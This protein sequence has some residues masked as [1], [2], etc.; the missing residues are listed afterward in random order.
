MDYNSRQ[1]R[2]IY[3]QTE[4]YEPLHTCTLPSMHTKPFKGPL[5]Y[6]DALCN[7]IH[8]C[9]HRH[10]HTHT[11]TKQALCIQGK[12]GD[13]S[14]ARTMGGKQS[15]SR[16]CLS[17]ISPMS[18]VWH[19]CAS[20]ACVSRQCIEQTFLTLFTMK[21]AVFHFNYEKKEVERWGNMLML[22]CEGTLTSAHTA[23]QLGE[24]NYSV[25]SESKRMGQEKGGCVR[26]TH[27]N[28]KNRWRG[29]GSD[30]EAVSMGPH[31][32]ICKQV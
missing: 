3:T 7:T 1:T 11:C 21:R 16:Y 2:H 22:L 6:T 12:H 9:K 13:M 14:T 30:R 31:I 19:V 8:A 26:R 28:T 17:Q 15:Q 24:L 27:T 23:K 5:D 20:A 25:R 4:A 18:H 32:Q 10:T 29:R